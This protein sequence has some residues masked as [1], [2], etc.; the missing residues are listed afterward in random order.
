MINGHWKVINGVL[1]CTVK[2]WRVDSDRCE[3]CA[4]FISFQGKSLFILGHN[5]FSTN[6]IY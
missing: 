6:F 2:V 4:A 5:D 3:K 1:P